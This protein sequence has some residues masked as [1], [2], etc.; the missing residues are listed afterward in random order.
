MEQFSS[1]F[2]DASTPDLQLVAFGTSLVSEGL[3]LGTARGGIGLVVV[4]GGAWGGA[5]SFAQ[6]VDRA[7]RDP[8]A[9]VN[10]PGFKQPECVLIYAPDFMRN[11][12]GNDRT[13]DLRYQQKDLVGFSVSN[14]AAARRLCTMDGLSS[15]FVDKANTTCGGKRLEKLM[16]APLSVTD[17]GN[18]LDCCHRRGE[19]HWLDGLDVPIPIMSEQD[20]LTD[21]NQSGRFIT[22]HD[23]RMASAITV[24]AVSKFLKGTGTGCVLGCGNHIGCKPN[25]CPMLKSFFPARACYMCFNTCHLYSGK[26][27][28]SPASLVRLAQGAKTIEE[29]TKFH[30]LLF[31]S[32][33]CIVVTGVPGTGNC[34]PCKSCYLSHLN[35]AN[36][37]PVT[38]SVCPSEGVNKFAIR[39]I[40]LGVWHRP[41]VRE[42][43]L[44]QLTG[45]QRQAFGNTWATFFRHAVYGEDTNGLQNLYSIVQLVA[46]K[47]FQKVWKAMG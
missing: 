8:L 42:Y 22:P 6:M 9:D 38:L 20:L 17:C 15:L 5:L 37:T 36:A 3:N 32:S 27:A 10:S 14:Q 33:C 1:G 18:C 43:F 45:E 44:A 12:T 25:E 21:T 7:N 26:E 29:K 11:L 13:E 39:S 31:D 16:D 2:D 19:M 30:K 4:M 47:E 46:T 28:T 35:E 23:R 24:G 41:L 34:L 40:L